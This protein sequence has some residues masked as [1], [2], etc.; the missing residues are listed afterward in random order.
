[1]S[2]LF[3]ALRPEENLSWDAKLKPV[4]EKIKELAR[5]RNINT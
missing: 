3:E 2:I 1:M 4:I 5:E